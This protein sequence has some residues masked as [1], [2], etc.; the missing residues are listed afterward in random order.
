MKNILEVYILLI[1]LFILRP[2]HSTFVQ[3]Q[4]C[5]INED[6]F[7]LQPFLIDASLDEPNSKLKFFI[8]TQVVSYNNTNINS[9]Q[10]LIND[11][12]PLSNKYTT[13][14]IEID[15]MGKLF[16]S[17]NK[18]FCDMLAVKNTTS[19][20][21]GPRFNNTQVQLPNTPDSGSSAAATNTAVPTV[22]SA[23]FNS[24][25]V[26][27]RSWQYVDRETLAHVFNTTSQLIQCPLYYNDSIILYYEADISD[28]IHHLGSYQ[29]RF[30]VVSNDV[31]SNVIGCSKTY[32]TPVQPEVISDIIN[33]GVLILIIVTAIVNLFTISYSCYQESSNPF[34][35]HASTICNAELLKQV[36]ATVPGIIMYLQFALFLGGL[37]IEYPGFYQPII[38]QIRW[39]ALM[40]YS[41]LSRNIPQSTSSRDNIYVTINSG[42]L[43]SLT[44]YSTDES[45]VDSWPNFIIC[46][47]IIIMIVIGFEQLFIFF[48]L[49]IDRLIKRYNAKKESLMNDETSE[50]SLISRNNGYFIL[51]QVFHLYL[52]IFG[53]PF[54]VLTSFMFLLA[55]DVNGKKKYFPN[56]STLANDAFSFTTSYDQLFLP[57]LENISGQTPAAAAAAAGGMNV[58]EGVL[59]NQTISNL[60]STIIHPGY[61]S[62]PSITI[63]FG[64]LLF[65]LWIGLILFFIF[66]YLVLLKGA[67]SK[68]YTSLKTILLWAF[69]YNEYKPQRVAFVIYD[70]LTLFIKSLIIGLVQNTG[71]VQVT[72]LIIIT[73]VD[74]LALLVV[75]PHFIGITLWS[76]KWMFPMARFLSTMLCIPFIKGLGISEAVR[77][78][79][80]YVQ[81]LI[82]AIV[83]II[84]L[85]QLLY[86][87]TRTLMSIYRTRQEARE[88]EDE[89]KALGEDGDGNVDDFQRDFEYRPIIL[90]EPR[91][92][93]R[94]SKFIHNEEQDDDDEEEEEEDF[95]YRKKSEQVLARL[96]TAHTTSTSASSMSTP[97]PI[98]LQQLPP[99]P[100]QL[101]Q[102]PPVRESTLSPV[103]ELEVSSFHEQQKI[104]NLRKKHTDYKVR[105]G[106]RIFEKYFMDELMDPEIKALWDS[107]KLEFSNNTNGNGDSQQPRLV[108]GVLRLKTKVFR[109]LRIDEEN[110]REKGFEV[111][112]PKQLVVRTLDEAMGKQ[113]GYDNQ[114]GGGQQSSSEQR[115]HRKR[116]SSASEKHRMSDDDDDDDES[117]ISTIKE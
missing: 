6:D 2:T 50:F 116:R 47:I 42:G 46:L 92:I 13:L 88:D 59:V 53:M 35:F 111:C 41:V 108:S 75:R 70:I 45:I 5:N 38:G 14:H 27:K 8:N 93:N 20:R 99:P 48:K 101:V 32:I 37:D 104:S 17:E 107:R 89:K 114:R 24:S 72:L 102:Q 4:S 57:V 16:I 68:L 25:T 11:V 94:D 61:L 103:E 84:F 19:F 54:L 66:N 15:F 63:T 30:S 62:I 74:L 9:S 52:L 44:V 79:V 100:Q 49:C 56:L 117:R 3:S 55:G 112:R 43:K 106:D 96:E 98:I 39:C 76:S 85:V 81:L 78:Y 7:L 36:D 105:E 60:N 69:Y 31:I 26:A 113:Q 87:F 21:E 64:S 95:Y 73:I 22:V 58:D 28:H 34:L 91:P 40:G 10:I 115:M 83:A 51:G 1:L 29:V 65:A 109:M 71:L 86:W 82:H 80:A 97:S 12:N 23:P 77:T 90:P 18:R 67:P 33:Y 110:H